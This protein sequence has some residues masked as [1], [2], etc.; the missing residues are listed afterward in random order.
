MRTWVGIAFIE[1]A[2]FL[3][4]RLAFFLT[5]ISTKKIVK[6]FLTPFTFRLGLLGG[7]RLAHQACCELGHKARVRF[8]RLNSIRAEI[9]I[10][11]FCSVAFCTATIEDNS[12]TLE[13]NKIGR[14][15][16]V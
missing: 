10:V 6:R 11:E 4:A 9:W 5:A 8:R 2:D 15:V 3:A 1:R 16:G 12:A 7:I 14:S 13:S